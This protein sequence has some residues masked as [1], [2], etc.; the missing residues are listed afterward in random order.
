MFTVSNLLIYVSQGVFL[1]EKHISYA[2]PAVENDFHE[3]YLYVI[4]LRKESENAQT[5]L[6]DALSMRALKKS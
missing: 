5:R 2:S 4:S 6:E 1:Y 3:A